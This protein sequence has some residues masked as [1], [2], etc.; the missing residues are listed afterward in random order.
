MDMEL[1]KNL[2][3]TEE[4]KAFIRDSATMQTAEMNQSRVVSEIYFI[5]NLEILVNRIIQSNEKLSNSNIFY[6]KGI[7][8]CG[9]VHVQSS[10]P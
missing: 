5:K 2:N 7:G 4:E 3:I 6:A 8:G 9:K 1:L 10:E